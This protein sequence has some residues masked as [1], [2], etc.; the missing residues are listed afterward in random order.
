[1]S[2]ST[3]SFGLLA[4]A[5]VGRSASG[6]LGRRSGPAEAQVAVVRNDSDG[7][8]YMAEGGLLPLLEKLGCEV[9]ARRRSPSPRTRRPSTAPG[10]GRSGEPSHRRARSQERA[11][12]GTG[13]GPS[14]ELHRSPRDVGRA[15]ALGP[16]RDRSGPPA[17]ANEGKGSRASS[18]CA[19]GSS[20]S[21]PT[22]ISTRRRRR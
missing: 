17:K 5:L 21:T 15:P 8:K 22:P 13:P 7:P 1:M 2:R 20:T 18:R 11:G 9:R 14:H 16:A 3:S 12:R 6:G 10:T 19:S 4:L